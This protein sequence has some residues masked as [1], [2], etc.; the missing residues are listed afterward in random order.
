[1]TRF[2]VNWNK[3]ELGSQKEDGKFSEEGGECRQEQALRV[4]TPSQSFCCCFR[5]TGPQ[6]TWPGLLLPAVRWPLNQECLRQPHSA[7][8]LARAMQFVPPQKSPP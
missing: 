6:S 8:C 5:N 3:P 7:R 1:M 4:A 2:K